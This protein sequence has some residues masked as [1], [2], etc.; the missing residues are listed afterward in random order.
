MI[1]SKT[2][3]KKRADGPFD[4]FW[5]TDPRQPGLMLGGLFGSVCSIDIT[6]DAEQNRKTAALGEAFGFPEGI[7]GQG[8]IDSCLGTVSGNFRVDFFS[9]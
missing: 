4:K 1:Y 9:G 5:T 8:L 6:F 3:P 7:R 2:T